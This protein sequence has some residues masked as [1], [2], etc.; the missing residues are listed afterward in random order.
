MAHILMH[1]I[2]YIHLH[3]RYMMSLPNTI[4]KLKK[5]AFIDSP[6]FVF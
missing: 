6:S 2:G 1:P 4:R 5:K 3:Q